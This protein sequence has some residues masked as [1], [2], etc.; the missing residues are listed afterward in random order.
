MWDI[1]ND[2]LK[3]MTSQAEDQIPKIH[4]ILRVEETVVHLLGKDIVHKI[5][6]FT[7]V[8]KF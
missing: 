5:F 8:A 7:H 4:E 1:I 6:N 2:W 3:W